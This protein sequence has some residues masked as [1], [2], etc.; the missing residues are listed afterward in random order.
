MTAPTI[1]ALV[2]AYAVGGVEG[3]R[4]AVAALEPSPDLLSALVTAHA[5][6]DAAVAA[7][8]V[9]RHWLEGGT[10]LGSRRT[11]ALVARLGD[12]GHADARLHVCQS[13]AH[14][15][16]PDRSSDSLADF[17][18]E[19]AGDEHKLVRAWA[20]DGFVRLAA[21]HPRFTEEAELWLERGRE[22]PAA[23]VRARV[24]NIDR[25]R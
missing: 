23:S 21:Q 24:R 20:I 18:R 12:L 6:P 19:A 10:S 7:S 1:Q 11:A 16:V 4:R 14:Y 25:G 2:D 13:I 3:L 5:D 8:W 22:D 15:D 17:L 9:L